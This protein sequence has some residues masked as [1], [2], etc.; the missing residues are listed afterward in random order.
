MPE[1]LSVAATD[2]TC[3]AATPCA[4]NSSASSSATAICAAFAWSLSAPARTYGATTRGGSGGAGGE[5]GTSITGAKIAG[6]A[7]TIA[8][9]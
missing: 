6:P 8:S 5:S 2:D 1:K 3:F 9:W 7:G 4:G